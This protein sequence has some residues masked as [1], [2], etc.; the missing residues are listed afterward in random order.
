[1]T[2]WQK[3]YSRYSPTV[4]LLATGR[5]IDQTTFWMS[6]PFMSLFI[7]R[8]GASYVMTGLVLAL[9][10]VAQLIGNVF[11]GQWSDRS[12]RRPVILTAGSLR[13]LVLLGFAFAHQIWHFAVLS[14][15]MGFVN[16]LFNPAYTSAIA[17]VTPPPMRPDAF[18][19][20][21]VMSNLGVG[22]GPLLGGLLGVGAQRL[23][24]ST[25]ALA[26]LAVTVRFLLRLPETRTALGGQ[27]PGAHRASGP[28]A[29]IRD[30]AAVLSD[31]ALLLFI[32]GGILSQ[33]AYGQI[34]ATLA[35]NLSGWMPNYE[36]VFSM[37]WT[38]NGLIVVTLQ[39]PLTAIFRRMPMGVAATAGCLTYAI[40]YTLFGTAGAAWQIYAATAVWTVGEVTLAV[41]NT[42]YV[43]DIAPSALR[44]RYVGASSLQMALG[45]IVGPILGTSVLRASGGPTVMFMAAIAVIGA[46]VLFVLAEQ[47]RT[48]RLLQDDG[49]AA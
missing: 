31:R 9:N 14:F 44:A 32:A 37:V 17:D 13:V 24:F 41:P 22:L 46:G 23:L 35:L 26:S 43:T 39:L 10:P 45:G 21:R 49:T 42:T 30:W 19:L 29:M 28:A 27:G 15:A 18:A 38:L 1:M 47:H 7:N 2:Y 8:A 25:A 4:W 48:R 12:G 3:I 36:R 20:S 33:I 40:G 6:L 5:L 16:A 34:N 11:G